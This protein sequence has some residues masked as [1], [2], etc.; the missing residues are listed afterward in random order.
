MTYDPYMF[1]VP[2][3]R[4]VGLTPAAG[5]RVLSRPEKVS[6]RDF[7]SKNVIFPQQTCN[8]TFLSWKYYIFG[9]EI[10]HFFME[11][12]HSSVEVLLAWFGDNISSA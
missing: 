2:R 5:L 9:M 6:A 11:V 12:L 10:L 4:L 8:T 1:T 7:H 3:S